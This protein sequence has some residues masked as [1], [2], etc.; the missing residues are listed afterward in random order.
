MEAE[1]VE[2]GGRRGEIGNGDAD[3]E[4]VEQAGDVFRARGAV[5]LED[6]E[7]VVAVGEVVAVGGRGVGG[8]GA[9]DAE[10]EAV[11]PEVDG[12]RE[13]ARAHANVDKYGAAH[14]GR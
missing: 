7:V 11:A 1:A 5:V 2:A 10:A 12:A 4:V 14:G 8:Y 3:V 13:V 6:A 9:G